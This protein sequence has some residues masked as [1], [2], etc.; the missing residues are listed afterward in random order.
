[1]WITNYKSDFTNRKFSSNDVFKVSLNN[2]VPESGFVI[3]P[4][5]QIISEILRTE[6]I[7]DLIFDVPLTDESQAYLDTIGIDIKTL[8]Q[9]IEK[10][11][12]VNA[13][14]YLGISEDD[15]RNIFKVPSVGKY[16]VKN[17]ADDL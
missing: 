6:S 4:Y 14:N 3:G 8:T 12:I 16:L 5:K 11:L 13:G 9:M 10:V 7:K 1:M 2:D 15:I 17:I